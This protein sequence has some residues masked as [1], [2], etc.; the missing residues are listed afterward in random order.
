MNKEFEILNTKL[1][2]I[3]EEIMWL[4]YDFQREKYE[5]E[6]KELEYKIKD[7]QDNLEKH[8]ENARFSFE[9]FD[10]KRRSFER[11]NNMYPVEEMVERCD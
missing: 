9:N 2:A 4:R 3:F 7:A 11:I 10:E 5:K 8:K 6:T 1:N